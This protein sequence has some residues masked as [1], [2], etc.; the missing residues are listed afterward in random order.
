[1]MMNFTELLLGFLQLR[2]QMPVYVLLL[3]SYSFAA[4][5]NMTNRV[6]AQQPEYR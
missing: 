2:R 3:L 1:M 5:K 6:T 4:I